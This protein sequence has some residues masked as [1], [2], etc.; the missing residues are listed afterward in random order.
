[1]QAV[2]NSG[3]DHSKSTLKTCQISQLSRLWSG[4]E[5]NQILMEFRKYLELNELLADELFSLKMAGRPVYVGAEDQALS[6]AFSEIDTEG[7]GTYRMLCES[8]RST[9]YLDDAGISPFHWYTDRLKR[10]KKDRLQTPP[11]IGLLTVLATAADH[12]NAGDGLAAHNYY[13]RLDQAL[14][15][16][17]GRSQRIRTDYQ[18]H[19][20]ELWASLN[21]WLEAWEGSRGVPTAY[22]V[23][24]RHVGLP[25]SQ[26][27]VREHDR[28]QLIRIFRA[29]G[30]APG[31]QMTPRD[32]EDVL[33]AWVSRVPSPLSHP[34]R[35]LW[36]NVVARE[37][38]LSVACLE[39]ESWDGAGFGED[40]LG[41]S[42]V[43]SFGDVRLVAT[44]R[45]FPT[46][47][48]EL[49]LAVPL[50]EAAVVPLVVTSGDEVVELQTVAGPAGTARL[51]FPKELD[52]QSLLADF[53]EGTLGAEGRGVERRPRRV[54]PLR[55]NDIQNCYV[56]TERVE[57]GDRS[58]ILA[59]AVVLPKLEKLLDE[60]ARPGFKI[61][62]EMPGLPGGWVVVEDVQI[63]QISDGVV[64]NDLLPLVPRAQTSLSLSGGLSLPGN[65][66]KWSTL[67]PPEIHAVAVGAKQL[68]VQIDRGSRLG[69]TVSRFESEDESA[70]LNLGEYELGD[71]EYLLTLYVNGA[72]KPVSSSILRLRSAN[73][74]VSAEAID[75]GRLV[76]LVDEDP[77]W[78]LTAHARDASAHWVDGVLLELN[79]DIDNLGSNGGIAEFAPRAKPAASPRV[80]SPKLRIGR[81][82]GE[83]SCMTTG[84][85][86]FELPPA[87]AGKPVS[88]SVVGECETCGVVKRFPTT[89]WGAR[90]KAPKQHKP[91][92]FHIQEKGPL[93]PIGSP[94]G[95][96]AEILFDSV[97]HV[98]SGSE[99]DL[100]R[101]AGNFEATALFTDTY[102]RNLEAMG[103]IDVSRDAL[104]RP[105]EWGV[106]FPVVVPTKPG[107]SFL[108][109]RTSSTML[110]DLEQVLGAAGCK[111]ERRVDG[112]LQSIVIRGEIRP[113]VADEVLGLHDVRVLRS[114]P[115]EALARALP[116]IES[117]ASS[118]E[119][120]SIPAAKTIELWDTKSARW[121]VATS[122][123]SPGAY[124]IS[125]FSRIYCIRTEQD[126]AS[127]KIAVANVQLVKHIANAWAHDPLVGY[128]SRTKSLLVPRGAD[129]PGLYARA[130]VVASGRVPT[131]TA[132]ALQYHDIPRSL[133]D[134]IFD[135]LA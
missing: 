48:M 105:L 132:A 96:A 81:Q 10:Q 107:H 100:G 50:L 114:N 37:G 118:L 56:E 9:L 18:A 102:L 15:V 55:W 3:S 79:T 127:G 85:H 131:S 73:S 76:H 109:G 1:M 115:S 32:M 77:R 36:T 20:E 113:D 124:R 116:P 14:S 49:N 67:A 117:L 91:G 97:C 59:V 106:N 21:N 2:W 27:L 130:L 51:A 68:A 74:P 5:G 83:T 19:S 134:I 72:T 62:S 64:H 38:M 99:N 75:G 80:I 43:K 61:S 133:A 28:N 84:M 95:A 29:E 110:D 11:T 57:Y 111:L 108:S 17:P 52:H 120:Q 66:R 4:A 101:I 41:H 123:M 135:R 65:L 54:V 78:P 22:S 119:R 71:D 46:S 70:I 33:D 86:R 40:D 35:S 6:R 63:M 125:N 8:V 39:L 121:V 126:I 90:K 92:Q 82:V 24:H 47:V 7:I 89:N 98:G 122:L 103:H 129:L 44:V 25:M 30:L 104:F 34:F 69:D 31:F 12:M 13:G 60:V 128:H 112:Q 16:P 58:L 94:A 42:R 53:V 88:A 87:A 26:A 23:G 93:E 45:V